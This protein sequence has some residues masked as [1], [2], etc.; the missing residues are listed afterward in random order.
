MQAEYS[1]YKTNQDVLLDLV[2]R[3]QNTF[4]SLALHTEA[5][6]IEQIQQRLSSD[7]FKVLVV[8]EFK[9][10]KSTLINA[11]LGQ[12]IL[13]AYAT[14]CT[15]VINEIKWGETKRAILHFANPLPEQLPETIPQVALDH[16]KNAIGPV[17]PLEIPVDQLE[18]YV[19]IPDPTQD[20]GESV[21]TTPYELVELHWPL[22][23]CKNGVEIIDSPGLN[24]HRARTAV[25]SKYITKVDAV[26]FVMSCHRL[27]SQS[28]MTVVDRDIRGNGHEDI[29]FICN[30][31]D[32]IRE[33]ERE[34]LISYGVQK[35]GVKTSFD[36]AG[37]YFLSA[38][39]ALD[40][41][42]E[43]KDELIDRSGV[44]KL[45]ADLA[46]FLVNQRGRIKLLQPARE[47]TSKISGALSQ[48]IPARL[49]MLAGQVDELQ[50]RY[51]DARPR[52][53]AAEEQRRAV[54]RRMKNTVERIKLDV[55]RM[56]RKHLREIANAV[57][58]WATEYEPEEGLELFSREG[59][60]TQAKALAEKMSKAWTAEMERLETEWQN[61][62]FKPWLITQTQAMGENVEEDVQKFLADLEQLRTD[63]TGHE[64]LPET[65]EASG[66]DRVLSAAGGFVLGGAGSAFVGGML[67]WKQMLISIVP[68]LGVVVGMALLGLT[69]PWILIPA[70]LGA[71]GIQGFL[72]MGKATKV[73]KSKVGENIAKQI[74]E[75]IDN[76]SAEAASKVAEKLMPII[77][78]VDSGMKMK[79][80]TLQEGVQAALSA[81]SCGREEADKKKSEIESARRSLT[82]LQDEINDIVF[83][84]AGAV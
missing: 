67:G 2:A 46:G 30:R 81:L 33:R 27:G 14:P 20:Q 70:L 59:P 50:A 17:P 65:E 75:N 52:F 26:V 55:E 84:L 24:E 4:C 3:A 41:R 79:L 62:T 45:E 15:A 31:F 34:R 63:L 51:E 83:T 68:Q 71:G 74:E 1:Q 13:P 38:V 12:E 16:I 73:L 69:N 53:E 19:V 7:S 23:V 64:Y 60:K 35:L 42:L 25:T 56:Y 82:Q 61:E 21:A 6:T 78:A 58:D 11:L 29:F 5:Q 57:S 72:S 37:V 22:D 10:G 66:L 77:N 47:I 44:C 54:V 39:D 36:Q 9:T 18:D 40:G 80:Q 76:T 43:D 48:H 49:N 28:E 32:E 8:G